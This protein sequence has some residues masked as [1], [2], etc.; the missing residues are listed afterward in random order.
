MNNILI[1]ILGI[2]FIFLMT[3]LGASLVFL[4]KNK[5]GVK[6]IA[7]AVMGLASG[8][9][10]SASI[11]SLLLPAFEY[12]SEDSAIKTIIVVLV[13]MIGGVLIGGMGIVFNKNA[14]NL[15]TTAKK[16]KNK[17]LYTNNGF[18]LQVEKIKK[19]TKLYKLFCLSS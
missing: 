7:G 6:N 18:D 2:C 13:F 8:I 5:S 19:T 9:M 1:V 14:K 12:V 17:V 3:T 11:W 15:K 4:F 10:I 16:C